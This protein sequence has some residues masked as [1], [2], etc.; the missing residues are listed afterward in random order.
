MKTAAPSPAWRRFFA[1]L[2]S[3]ALLIPCLARAADAQ[4]PGLD[5]VV[6]DL[7]R[8]GLVIYV[9]H[10]ATLPNNAGD[11]DLTSCDRQRNLSEDGR[12]YAREVGQ[13][14]RE[15]KIPIGAVWTSPYCR[16]IDTARL[17]FGKLA[18]NPNLKSSFG[19]TLEETREGNQ[20]LRAL[21]STQPAP[22]TNVVVVSH[23]SNIR[24]A[25]GLWPK[26]EGT[27]FVFRPLGGDR[28]EAIAR[29]SPGEWTRLAAHLARR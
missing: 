9:R 16:C 12:A 4:L 6:G 20:T 27:A 19:K 15:L 29:I 25:V 1:L 10:A 21:L 11:H 26:P 2:A 18:V 22:G 7:Q 13:V 23:S 24:D 28:F 14:V 3:A 8:G 5:S 17:A